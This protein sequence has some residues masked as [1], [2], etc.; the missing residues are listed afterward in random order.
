MKLAGCKDWHEAFSVLLTAKRQLELQKINPDYRGPILKQDAENIVSHAPRELDDLTQKFYDYNDNILKIAVDA[1]L[2]KQEIYDELKAKYKHY[3]SMARD[4]SSG[5]ETNE[6]AILRL[7]FIILKKA[8][9]D[10]FGIGKVFF[11]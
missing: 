8:L 5:I 4:F 10:L 3:A 7:R 11:L 6:N 2:I 9:T 1:G